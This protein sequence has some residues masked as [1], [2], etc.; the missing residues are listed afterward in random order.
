MDETPPTEASLRLRALAREIAGVCVAEL[1][2]RAVLLTGSAAE[3]LSDRWSDLD[4]IVY[5]D[6]LPPEPAIDAVRLRLG[7]GDLSVLAPW[8]GDSY[9]QSF[10]LRGVEC[11]VGHGTV[12]GI[13]REIAQVL[14]ELDVDSPLQK[15]FDG[16]A[17]GIPL[18]RSEERRVGKECRSR[19]SPYH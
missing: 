15:A 13:D 12:A 1:A 5:H 4:V 7:G 2:P 14:V 16:M 19:W 11:Q 17:H 3:G 10:P 6:R 9:S 8:D 18:H